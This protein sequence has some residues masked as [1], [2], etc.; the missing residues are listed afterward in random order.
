MGYS[1]KACKVK[2][3]KPWALALALALNDLD[4]FEE[5]WVEINYFELNLILAAKK[6]R[7]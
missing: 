2:D 3:Q 1:G 4:P 5:G 7:F 6:P